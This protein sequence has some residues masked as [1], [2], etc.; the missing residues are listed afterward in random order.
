[1]S[2]KQIKVRFIVV[3]KLRSSF[4]AA[5][6]ES[7]CVVGGCPYR[8]KSIMSRMGVQV[9]MQTKPLGVGLAF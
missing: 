6:G 3:F 8:P 5:L 4:C 2:C 7:L 1:V 9:S